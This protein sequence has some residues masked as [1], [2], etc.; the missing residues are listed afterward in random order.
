[1]IYFVTTA[2]ADTVVDALAQEF[3]HEPAL[4]GA[5]RDDAGEIDRTARHWFDVGHYLR[6]Y[7]HDGTLPDGSREFGVATDFP[8]TTRA[9]FARL[10]AREITADEVRS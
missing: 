2:D 7:P 10:G 6:L 9:V 4:S 1:M 5:A 3:G 8:D